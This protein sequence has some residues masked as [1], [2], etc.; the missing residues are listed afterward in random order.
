[1][2][3]FCIPCLVILIYFLVASIFIPRYRTYI[4]EGWRCFIDKLRGKECSV[5]FD[6]KMRLVTSEWFARHHMPRVGKFLYNKRNFDWTLIIV[7][8]VTTILTI[9]LAYLAYVFWFVQ[10]PCTEETCG[11]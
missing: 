1:M 7:G 10:P 8:V 4:K 5:S 3:F 6:N 2:V 9:Y 11:I